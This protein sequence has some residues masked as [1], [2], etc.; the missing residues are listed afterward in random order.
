RDMLAAL[1]TQKATVE[2]ADLR[3]SEI[4][5]RVWSPGELKLN[6]VIL[7]CIETWIFLCVIAKIHRE[8]GQKVSVTYHLLLTNSSVKASV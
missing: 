2:H 6:G 5:R 3:L 1:S 4:H 8:Y 7:L